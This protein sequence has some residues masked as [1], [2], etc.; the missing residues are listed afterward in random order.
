MASLPSN[1][2]SL[3]PRLTAIQVDE[4]PMWR[5]S[6]GTMRPAPRRF[7]ATLPPMDH[8]SRRGLAPSSPG[9]MRPRHRG[10][11]PRAT[12]LPRARTLAGRAEL[13]SPRTQWAR[14]VAIGQ[15]P[16]WSVNAHLMGAM[17][18]NRKHGTHRVKVRRALAAPLTKPP[19]VI[20]SPRLAWSPRHPIHQGAAWPW[21]ALGNDAPRLAIDRGRRVPSLAGDRSSQSTHLPCP[22]LTTGRL[23]N[24]TLHRPSH[25]HGHGD[26]EN[27]ALVSPID[28]RNANANGP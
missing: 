22:A 4:S 28:Q 9:R 20:A 6:L 7:P 15:V 19:W 8:A 21:R 14:S 13:H 25:H 3:A 16:W 10:A 23:G 5:A 12:P 11:K 17:L 18:T 24:N 2:G 27:L 1:L 26:R